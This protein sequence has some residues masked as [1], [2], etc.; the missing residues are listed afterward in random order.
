MQEW[1][2]DIIMANG[3]YVLVPC[4]VLTKLACVRAAFAHVYWTEPGKLSWL[5]ACSLS[6]GSPYVGAGCGSV[7]LGKSRIV[8]RFTRRLGSLSWM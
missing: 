2:P 1:L 6:T 7:A 8:S 3:D 5:K 4:T